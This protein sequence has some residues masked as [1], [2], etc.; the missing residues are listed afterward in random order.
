MFTLMILYCYYWSE[1]GLRFSV[2][3]LYLLL[4]QQEKNTLFIKYNFTGGII[5]IEQGKINQLKLSN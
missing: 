1:H 2:D 5:Q 3:M 4:G